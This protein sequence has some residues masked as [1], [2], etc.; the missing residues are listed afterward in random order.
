[1][2]SSSTFFLIQKEKNI[3]SKMI[4]MRY[5]IDIPIAWLKLF[6]KKCIVAK[7]TDATYN[8]YNTFWIID[9]ICYIVQNK[10]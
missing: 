8:Y 5:A 10:K 3:K 4:G 1:M 7:I 6:L 9:S 2:T